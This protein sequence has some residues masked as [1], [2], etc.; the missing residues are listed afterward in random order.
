MPSG[1][2]F[3]S[4][5]ARCVTS[6]PP[7]HPDVLHQLRLLLFDTFRNPGHSDGQPPASYEFRVWLVHATIGAKV[8]AGQQ[9]PRK[10]SPGSMVTRGNSP[11]E[12]MIV[13]RT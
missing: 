13:E 2:G 1:C 3:G 11:S 9:P 6:L 4:L 5:D 12:Y 8:S 7:A 10:Q